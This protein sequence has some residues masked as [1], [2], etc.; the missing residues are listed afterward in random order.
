M[1]FRGILSENLQMV[2]SINNDAIK[3]MRTTQGNSDV[4]IHEDTNSYYVINESSIVTLQKFRGAVHEVSLPE[5]DDAMALG[6]EIVLT[7]TEKLVTSVKNSK[8]VGL[9]AHNGQLDGL[10]TSNSV[11]IVFDPSFSSEIIARD[12]SFIIKSHSFM[13]F[14]GS[15]VKIS[16]YQDGRRY[17]LV[18]RTNIGRPSKRRNKPNDDENRQTEIGPTFTTCENVKEAHISDFPEL[19]S[20][21][22]HQNSIF[23]SRTTKRYR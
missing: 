17:W 8:Y 4:I 5:L 18:T 6:D 22:S 23:Y 9:F 10:V 7:D 12:P 14:S 13:K 19:L 20:S 2:F 1:D 3:A 16:L 21:I 15:E 11:L